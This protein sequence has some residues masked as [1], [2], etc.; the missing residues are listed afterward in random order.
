MSYARQAARQKIQ[1]A[2]VNTW[3]QVSGEGTPRQPADLPPCDVA[4]VMSTEVEAE[5]LS[6]RLEGSVTTRCASFVEHAGRWCGRQVVIAECGLGAKAAAKATAD[7]IAIH[8]PAWVVSAGFAAALADHLRRGHILMADRVANSKQGELAVGLK[9]DP[10]ALAEIKG[11]HVGRLLTIDRLVHKPDQKRVLGH[12]HAAL[13]CDMETMSVAEVCHRE[14][15][16]FLSVRVI[17]DALDDQW[18]PEIETLLD[19]RS[20]A[21]KLGAAAGAMWRRPAWVKDLLRLQE[22]AEL[23]SNRLAQ[24]CAGV[25]PQLAAFEKSA[26]EP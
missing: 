11:L 15:T 5:G 8:H 10:N 16:K 24:F 13:A 26:A 12:E 21:G 7:V 22:Q 4:F 17:S 18:P 25:I 3:Q 20:W 6:K 14:K 23:A 9:F 19:Q 2:V 1:E